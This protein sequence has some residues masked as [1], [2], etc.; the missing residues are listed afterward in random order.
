MYPES[1]VDQIGLGIHNA[2]HIQNTELH[3]PKED[4]VL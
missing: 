2:E 3:L 4:R 1:S